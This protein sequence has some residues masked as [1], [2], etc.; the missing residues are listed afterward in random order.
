MLLVVSVP[1]MLAAVGVFFYNHS[2]F[3]GSFPIVAGETFAFSP[4]V[5]LAIFCERRPRRSS[6]EPENP[7][8]APAGQAKGRGI[9]TAPFPRTPDLAGSYSMTCTST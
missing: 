6:S 9:P 4:F 7:D 3:H 1:A 2:R 8:K 5:S